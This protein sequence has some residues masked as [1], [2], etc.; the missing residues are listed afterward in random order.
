MAIEDQLRWERKHAVGGVVK[1]PCS[2]LRDILDRDHWQLSP[3]KALDLAC[4]SGRNALVLARRGFAVTAMDISPQALE[5]GREQ[6]RQ[7]LVQI[8]WQQADLERVRLPEREYDLVVNINYLQRSLIPQIRSAVKN[9]GHVIFETYLIEQMSVGHPR[10]P[11]YLL[12]HN[13]LLDWFRDFRVLLYREGEFA[14]AKA[15]SFR[16]G[17]FAQRIA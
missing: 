17:L 7:D 5:R 11:A 2:L 6:A 4:G 10:N 3:G 1:A 16:A 15:T 8:T 14:D 12:Q 9:G 13:E